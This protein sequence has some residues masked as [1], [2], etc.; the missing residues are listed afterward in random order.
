MLRQRSDFELLIT[1]L[2]TEAVEQGTFRAVEPHLATLQFLN[3]HNHTYQ[4]VRPD[5]SW[6]AAFLSGEY[7]STLFRGFAASVG[8]LPDVEALAVEF[9]RARPEL[10]SI[11]RRCGKR[12]PWRADRTRG[13]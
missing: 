2:L 1:G 4:W 6:D 13:A 11:P 5:G 9:K 10:P 7:C 3:L 8:D 12:S